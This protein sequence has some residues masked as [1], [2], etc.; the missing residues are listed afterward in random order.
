MRHPHILLAL[1]LALVFSIAQ[2][3]PPGAPPPTVT[4]QQALADIQAGQ[5]MRRL[6]WTTQGRQYSCIYWDGQTMR[7]YHAYIQRGQYP[8][9]G[10]R[11]RDMKN[12]W[13]PW[14]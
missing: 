3:A 13:H 9:W 5:C 1:I 11:G 10:L 8:E 4:W 14:Q 6:P 2:A 7:M 12:D